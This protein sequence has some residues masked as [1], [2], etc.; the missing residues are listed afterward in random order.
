MSSA[1]GEMSYQVLHGRA[2]GCCFCT[3]AALLIA[4]P[5]RLFAT[6]RLNEHNQKHNL[7]DFSNIA[8]RRGRH[9]GSAFFVSA[10]RPPDVK[11][12]QVQDASATNY[13]RRFVNNSD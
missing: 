3:A 6:R 13:G 7:E 11:A 4:V 8:L 12:A 9:D 1:A 10:V 2:H 5:A